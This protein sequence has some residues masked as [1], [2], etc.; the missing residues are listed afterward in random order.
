MARKEWASCSANTRN[1]RIVLEI[2]HLY[3]F[4]VFILSSA[5]I[6]NKVLQLEK[7]STRIVLGRD[8]CEYV[9]D[10]NS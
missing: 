6:E 5:L 4:L 8:V 7:K 1:L 2:G 3:K 10:I 9:Q